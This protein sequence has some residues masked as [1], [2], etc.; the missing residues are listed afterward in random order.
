MTGMH[1]KDHLGDKLSCRIVCSVICKVIL[2]FFPLDGCGLRGKEMATGTEWTFDAW[3]LHGGKRKLTRGM[4]W[5]WFL[6]LSYR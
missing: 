1:R 5:D 6:F 3:G 2:Y 4:D